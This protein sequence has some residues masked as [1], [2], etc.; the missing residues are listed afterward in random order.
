M[1]WLLDALF[2]VRMNAMSST[3]MR[4]LPAPL[5][6]PGKLGMTTV[7]S[8]LLLEPPEIDCGGLTLA[9]PQSNQ[10]RIAAPVGVAASELP[11]PD[12]E[13]G[14]GPSWAMTVRAV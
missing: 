3:T 5:H 7:S 14:G 9:P 8:M 6:G 12:A 2:S 11:E 10:G 13:V 1:P 4:G